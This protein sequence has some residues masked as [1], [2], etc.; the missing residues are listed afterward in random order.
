MDLRDTYVDVDK[1]TNTFNFSWLFCLCMYLNKVHREPLF[2]SAPF[3]SSDK[4]IMFNIN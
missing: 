4:K 3:H 2:L 1:L